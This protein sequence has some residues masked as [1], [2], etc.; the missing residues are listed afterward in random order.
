MEPRIPN[1]NLCNRLE[2]TF[3][4]HIVEENVPRSA[5]TKGKRKNISQVPEQ[6]QDHDIFNDQPSSKKLKVLKHTNSSNINHIL[7]TILE[8]FTSLKIKT[9]VS[10]ITQCSYDKDSY[11]RILND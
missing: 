10:L 3:V 8:S 7:S 5:P 6:S 1:W 11:E 9:K 2:P 4:S